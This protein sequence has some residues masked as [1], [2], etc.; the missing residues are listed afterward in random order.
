MFPR[1]AISHVLINDQPQQC[2]IKPSSVT[3]KI[4]P[5]RA[6]ITGLESIPKKTQLDALNGRY[7]YNGGL[8]LA[9]HFLVV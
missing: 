4:A 5:L 1:T 2:L 8:L 3:N 6:R 9:G 7:N